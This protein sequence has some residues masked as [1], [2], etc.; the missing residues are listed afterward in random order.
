MLCIVSHIL[1]YTSEAH[2]N[3]YRSLGKCYL[4]S[5]NNKGTNFAPAMTAVSG[6]ENDV[7]ADLR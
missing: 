1:G 6:A 7:S 5:F 3:G 2:M 4:A